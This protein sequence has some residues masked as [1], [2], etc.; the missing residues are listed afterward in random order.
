MQE[1]VEQQL[2][3]VLLAPQLE[4]GGL[5]LMVRFTEAVHEA[6]FVAVPAEPYGR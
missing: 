6:G 4:Q 3:A 1:Q 5:D 2:E